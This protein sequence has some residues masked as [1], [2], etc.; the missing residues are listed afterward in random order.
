MSR[1]LITLLFTSTCLSL[2]PVTAN[3]A[4]IT[5]IGD[6]PGGWVESF[7]R[8]ISGD[9]SVAVGSSANALGE[10]AYSWTSGGGIIDLGDL[11]GGTSESKSYGTNQ[12]G[13]IIVGYS[14][15][16]SGLEAFMWTSGGGM[17]GLGDLAGG[18]G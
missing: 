17:V 13:S 10:G 6:L 2:T 7:S 16:A 3:A 14:S 18:G 9:G 12:D 15:S 1:R 8:E 4:S 5:N 11:P